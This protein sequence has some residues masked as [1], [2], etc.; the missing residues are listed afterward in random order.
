VLETAQQTLVGAPAK[1]Q[2]ALQ[3][4]Q[5]LVAALTE[6][7]PNLNIY[8]DLSELRGFHYHTGI[9][10]AAYVPSLGQAL[11]KGGRYDEIGKVFGRARPATGFST[12]LKILASLQA[13]KQAKAPLV[14]PAAMLRDK[15]GRALLK[16]LRSKGERVILQADEVSLPEETRQQIIRKED[17]WVI[18]S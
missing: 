6:Q 5:Q 9:V 10:F 3:E 12:D 18:I 16:D 11:A 1:V 14:A 4:L 2:H 8:L 7:Y 15:A 17:Q 13:V